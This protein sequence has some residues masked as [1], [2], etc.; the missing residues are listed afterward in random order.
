M[1][2]ADF[3][4]GYTFAEF[5]IKAFYHFRNRNEG[6]RNGWEQVRQ[7]VYYG[8]LLHGVEMPPQELMPFTWDKQTRA[9]KK[10]KAMTASE[11]EAI[12]QRYQKMGLLGKHKMN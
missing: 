11:G 9:A 6:I 1:L 5:Q 3:W 4:H 2:P 12:L 10:P 7:Q 8:W